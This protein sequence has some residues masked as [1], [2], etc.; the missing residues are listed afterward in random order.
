MVRMMKVSPSSSLSMSVNRRAEG[1]PRCPE[2]TLWLPA[3]PMGR[4][5]QGMWPIAICSTPSSMPW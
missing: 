1:S 2:S 4:E 5:D 3:P